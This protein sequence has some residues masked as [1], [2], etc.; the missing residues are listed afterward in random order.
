MKTPEKPSTNP[1]TATPNPGMR[2]RTPLSEIP[3]DAVDQKPD[4]LNAV[5]D[6][7]TQQFCNVLASRM[8]KLTETKQ[9]E[10]K[11]EINASFARIRKG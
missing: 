10:L 2:T 11:D 3:V 1:I 4:V 9:E 8:R 5:V 7:E 6:D